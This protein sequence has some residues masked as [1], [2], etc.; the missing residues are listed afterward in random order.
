[1]FLSLGFVPPREVLEHVMGHLDL[2]AASGLEMLSESEQHMSM[3][4]FGNVSAGEVPRIVPA[5]PGEHVELERTR[6]HRH[7]LLEVR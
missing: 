5:L 4:A 6:L 1:M 2:P 7:D 3:T